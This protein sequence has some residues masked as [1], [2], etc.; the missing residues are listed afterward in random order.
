MV[1]EFDGTS[2]FCLNRDYL[3]EILSTDIAWLQVVTLGSEV[4]LFSEN[5]HAFLLVFSILVFAIVL[6]QLLLLV[7]EQDSINFC[8]LVKRAYIVEH[9][10]FL[11]GLRVSSSCID[12]ADRLL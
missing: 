9:R 2:F 5:L 4:A 10:L 7:L 8:V 11:L 1:I 12:S 6:L 3:V